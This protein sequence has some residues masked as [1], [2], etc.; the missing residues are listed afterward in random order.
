[1]TDDLAPTACML[2]TQLDTFK[3][4]GAKEAARDEPASPT[5]FSAVQPGSP[6]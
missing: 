3:F 1:M 4:E 5:Q 2:S 6:F